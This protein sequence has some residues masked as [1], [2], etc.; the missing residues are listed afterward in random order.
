MNLSFLSKDKRI[1]S[2]YSDEDGV[3]ITLKEEYL[4]YFDP[5][6]LSQTIHENHET[7]IKGIKFRLKLIK[8]RNKMRK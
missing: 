5:F 7:G 3:W 4:E 1:K 8:K 6:Y 2:F